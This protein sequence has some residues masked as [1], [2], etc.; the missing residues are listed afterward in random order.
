MIDAVTDVAG[1]DALQALA[2]AL[3]WSDRQI[4]GYHH[5]A[6]QALMTQILG[7]EL[8]CFVLQTNGVLAGVLPYRLKQT[9]RGTVINCL[10]F[11]G[12]NAM[13][14][15]ASGDGAELLSAFSERVHSDDIFTGAF[16]SPFG[17]NYTHLAAQLRPDETLVK[18]TQFL[19]LGEQAPMWPVKRRGDLRRAV[20]RGYRARKAIPADLERIWD[21]YVETAATANIPTKPRA[22]VE[23]TFEI[24]ERLGERSPLKWLVAEVDGEIGAAL[25]TGQSRLTGSYILPCA[26]PAH[27]A[28]QPSAFLLDVAIQEAWRTGVRFWNFESSPAWDDPVFKYKERWGATAMPFAIFV[29]YGLRGVRPAADE[30]ADIRRQAPF[31]FAA[32]VATPT[33]LW[34]DTVELPQ[35]FQR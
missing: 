24:A 2:T 12:S 6:Y 4:L 22:F 30:I 18:F 35:D 26:D 1:D 15:V 9:T 32:P 25:L 29:F 27:R 20:S 3:T 19:S 23:G 33:G 7:D 16:Y 13:V 31:Y 10:P 8:R 11:F 14:S 21:I 34:P 5:P 28:F 17:L